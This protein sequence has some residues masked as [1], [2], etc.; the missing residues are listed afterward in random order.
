MTGTSSATTVIPAA[1]T[2][3]S[4]ATITVTAP[5]AGTIVI[6]ANA[7]I[8]LDHTTGTIDALVVGIGT[9]ATDCG[10]AFDEVHYQI[11][12]AIPTYA[13]LTDNTFHVT[14]TFTVAA[15]TY[16][17]YL[18]AQMT[19]GAS[20]DRFWFASMQGAFYR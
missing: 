13:G 19:S 8:Q 2:N 4:G 12:A 11:P 1:C 7:W 20:G 15:G 6:D 3:Y 17:Y 16:T 5:T 10:T 14:R 18:N 9:S